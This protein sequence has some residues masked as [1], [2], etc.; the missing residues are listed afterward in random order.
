MMRVP[1]MVV[2]TLAVAMLIASPARSQSAAVQQLYA[3]AHEAQQAGQTER[4]IAIYRDLL[5][6][7]PSVA[8]AYNNLGRLLF[9]LDLYK[10]AAAVLEQ[11]V[12]LKPDMAPAQI[13]LGAS[14][15]Q[16][17]DAAKAIAPLERGIAG[18]PDDRFARQTLAQALLRVG[19]TEDAVGQLQKL[20]SLDPR[21][22]RSWY[23]LGKLELQ[24]SQQAFARMR[25]IDVNSP[26]SHQLSGE[27]MESMQ[28]T[29][30]AVAEYKQALALDANDTEAM[31]RL[32]DLYWST[33]D[34]AAARP[35]L[36]AFLGKKPGDCNA[37]WKLAR[38]LDQLSAPPDEVLAHAN[39]AAHA[40]PDLPEAR[41]ERARA[42]VRLNKPAEALIDLKAAEAKTPDEP[43]IQFLLA[44]AYHAQANEVQ[45]T[46]AMARFGELT[47]A[48]HDAKEKHAAEVLSANQ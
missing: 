37:E 39:A 32:A 41:V 25:A 38:A 46:A 22:Q 6:Q 48:E 23:L 15:L 34:W 12:A 45:A 3:Q 27:I 26:L 9:N 21:D 19:R 35:A 7:D 44:K 18:M 14:Y 16:M 40:C 36:A 11:G 1:H 30:G 10:E 43:S 8:A 13:M 4:A 20:V 28:N 17:N 2:G 31:W 33:G 42:L 5:H 47:R 24:L 29:P